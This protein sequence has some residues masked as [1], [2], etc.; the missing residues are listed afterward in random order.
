MGV[1]GHGGDG[2]VRGTGRGSLTLC[3]GLAISPVLSP[4]L[5]GLREGPPVVR[6]S[7]SEKRLRMNFRPYL[8]FRGAPA[9]HLRVA[10]DGLPTS[11]HS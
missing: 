11:C 9:S 8:A 4:G 5:P 1:M 7:A 3:G 10:V 2:E 6:T